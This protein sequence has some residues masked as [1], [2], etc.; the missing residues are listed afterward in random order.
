VADCWSCGDYGHG[1][2]VVGASSGLDLFGLLGL[3]ICFAYFMSY[4]IPFGYLLV[5]H[6]R[7]REI[8]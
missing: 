6:P 8:I 3:F 2:A 1:S 7:I 5:R 4:H